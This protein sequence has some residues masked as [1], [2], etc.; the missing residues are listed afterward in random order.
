M[1]SQY[2]KVISEETGYAV[3]Y[4]HCCIVPVVPNLFVCVG[5]AYGFEL[6]FYGRQKLKYYGFNAD[7]P[8]FRTK[9]VSV[10][11]KYS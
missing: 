9:S 5:F 6:L 11:I 7:R 3:Q 1:G 10:G 2:I 8:S 4:Y